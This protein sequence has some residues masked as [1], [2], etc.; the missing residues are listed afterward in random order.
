MVNFNVSDFSK[1]QPN[2]FGS[3]NLDRMTDNR[4]D[5]N[6]FEKLNKKNVKIVPVWNSSILLA[7][8]TSALFLI[9]SPFK[10]SKNT[11]CFS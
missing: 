3:D 9:G 2:Y 4:N 6:W 7:L 8:E 11:I 10:G 1:F 5:L